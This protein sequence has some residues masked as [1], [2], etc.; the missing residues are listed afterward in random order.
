MTVAKNN[1]MR[2]IC[3]I[4]NAITFYTAYKQLDA[5]E[6]AFVD[7]FVLNCEIA[8][9]KAGVDLSEYLATYSAV[10]LPYSQLRM[11]ERQ[12]VQAAIVER[13]REIAAAGEI[14][15]DRWLKEVATIAF[16]S[17]GNYFDG[18][19]HPST[20]LTECTPEQLA[21]IAGYDYE[22]TRYGPKVKIKLH[23]K[24]RALEMYG[25]YVGAMVDDAKSNNKIGDS[26]LPLGISEHNA[27]DIY[28]R[29]IE[30]E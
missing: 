12:I 7:G 30:H 24:L 1:Q 29:L 18:E 11:I 6:R 16:S 27:A 17:I 20:D 9:R 28:A 26:V 8:A 21:A 2:H 10:G 25:K 5:P 3:S 19:K 4:M 13:A 22:Q 15:V 23:D 14:S